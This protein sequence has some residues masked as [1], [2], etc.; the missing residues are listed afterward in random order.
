MQPYEKIPRRTPSEVAVS[1]LAPERAPSTDLS[2]SATP[3][4]FFSPGSTAGSSAL[5]AAVVAA[6]V[7]AG[8]VGTASTTASTTDS[9]A[10]TTDSDDLDARSSV[11]ARP[12]AEV[13]PRSGDRLEGETAIMG[14]EAGSAAIVASAS[15]SL[16]WMRACGRALRTTRRPAELPNISL[17]EHK[18][19]RQPQ[20]CRQTVGRSPRRRRGRGLGRN[21]VLYGTQ[22]RH[23]PRR[24]IRVSF[25][26]A[27]SFRDLR[28][29]HRAL[30]SCCPCPPEFD[31]RLVNF[32]P[33]TPP[34]SRFWTDPVSTDAA[35]S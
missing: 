27:A 23:F 35:P 4:H 13:R 20:H 24:H 17:H 22:S 10:S 6:A 7:V 32:L 8:A 19:E 26:A 33:V 31:K 5:A 18:Q 16:S 30:A 25:V 15:A 14:S 21:G 11:E 29:V 34:I 3:F 12:D 9:D 2:L 1:A 28:P